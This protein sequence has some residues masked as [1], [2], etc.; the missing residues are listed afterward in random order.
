MQRENSQLRIALLT[1]GGDSQG[2]N[3]AIKAIVRVGLSNN[4]QVYAIF[5]GYQGKA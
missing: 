2:M 5:N 1:S 4:A 3:A